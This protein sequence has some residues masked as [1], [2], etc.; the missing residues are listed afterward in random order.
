MTKY[1]IAEITRINRERREEIKESVKL[2]KEKID[3]IVKDSNS[4]K[5]KYPEYKEAFD[6]VNSLFPIVGI[7]NIT[8]YQTSARLLEKV[9]YAGVGGFYDRISKIIVVSSSPNFV[10]NKNKYAIQ[11]KLSEDEVIAHELIHYCDVEEKRITS[12]SNL[13]EEFAYGWSI[14]YLRQK[15]YTDEQIIKNN[16]LPYLFQVEHRKV[17]A[18]IV[19]MREYNL[20][21]AKKKER[22]YKQ[23]GR[24]IHKEAKEK[25][26]EQG[27]ILLKLYS[28]KLEEGIAGRKSTEMGNRFDLLDLS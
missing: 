21:S 13:A 8:I 1:S 28:D 27:W 24:R 15:G 22:F 26:I 14:G 5:I 4:K 23:Y 2:N 17:V 7:K 20:Y 6:Y 9:G 11:A 10:R 12:S 25:A 3:K 18:K 16:F 19:D